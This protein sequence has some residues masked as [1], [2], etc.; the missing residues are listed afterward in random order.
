MDTILKHYM[1]I[2][3]NAVDRKPNTFFFTEEVQRRLLGSLGKAFQNHF[4][5][6]HS[7]AQH[8]AF[9]SFC[10]ASKLTFP[11]FRLLQTRPT[12]I[13]P[14][15]GISPVA[16]YCQDGQ[17]GSV[18]VVVNNV[19]RWLTHPGIPILDAQLGTLVGVRLQSLNRKIEDVALRN[20]IEEIISWM[21]LMIRYKKGKKWEEGEW[22]LC[23]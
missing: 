11:C 3:W 22:F 17:D 13:S 15:I 14:Y 20:Q 18:S 10:K 7:E 19:L 8:Y 5:R 1:S 21:Y 2:Q 9:E 4:V 12:A 23:E 6:S 16:K